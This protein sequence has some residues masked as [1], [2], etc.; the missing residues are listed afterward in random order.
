MLFKWYKTAL[1]K[2]LHGWWKWGKLHQLWVLPRPDHSSRTHHCICVQWDS[3]ADHSL[4]STSLP[5]FCTKVLGHS[6]SLLYRRMWWCHGQHL[7]PIQHFT[8]DNSLSSDYPEQHKW[9]FTGS[10]SSLVL[11]PCHRRNPNIFLLIFQDQMHKAI[12]EFWRAREQ[13]VQWFT[14]VISCVSKAEQMLKWSIFVLQ[15]LITFS[16]KATDE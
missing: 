7:P 2:W 9:I 16:L 14:P 15:Y 5:E 4:W 11:P 1:R 6:H 8:S 3:P 12:I 13:S 10:G